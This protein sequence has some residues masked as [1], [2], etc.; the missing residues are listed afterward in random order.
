MTDRFAYLSATELLSAYRARALSPVE[1]T[2]ATL[3]RIDRLNPGLNAF[4]TVTHERAMADAR[5]AEAAYARGDAGSL[6]GVP[7]SIKDLTP[8]KGIRTTRGSKVTA[9]AVPDFDGVY[10]ERTTAAGAVMIGKT[11]TPEAGWKGE[12]SNPLVG[13]THN[14]WRKGLTPGGSSGGGSAAVA[15]GLGPLAQGSDGAGSIRIPAGFSGIVGHK[16]SYG[17]VPHYPISAV[18]DLAHLGPMT[19][20]VRDA[21]LLMNATAGAD[22]RDRLSWS[23]GIDYVAALDRPLPR[24]KIAWSADLGY[25]PTDPEVVAIAERAARRFIELGHTLDAAHPAATDPWEILDILWST[26]MNGLH[27]DG[28]DAIRD[29]IDPGRVAMMEAGRNRTAPQIG[30][31]P[32]KRAAYHKAVVDFFDQW[33]LLLTP[34]LPCKP[35][36]VGLHNPPEIAGK[37]MTYLGWTAFTYPFNLTGNPAISVP[38]GFTSDGLPVGLQIVGRFQRDDTVL[39]AAAAFE[40]IQPWAHIT[41]DETPFV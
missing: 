22:A 32:F 18:A 37:P 3:D 21:A 10:V 8:T 23:S 34:T 40:A 35:F 29:Q 4:I 2:A 24:L 16:P 39:Q 20:T 31:A 33:D 14:P 15:M 38:A 17:L 13:S 7:I 30:Q 25:A 11:N 1:V 41:P 36:P 5:A 26:G 28:F 12:T 27:P 9:D 6:A 19:R